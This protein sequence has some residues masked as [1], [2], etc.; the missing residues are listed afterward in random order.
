[1]RQLRLVLVSLLLT[2]GMISCKKDKEPTPNPLASLQGNWLTS[3]WGGA[4]GNNLVINISQTSASAVIQ[5][6]GS[7]T[8]NYSVG[9]TIL[10]NITAA[11]GSSTVFKCNAIFKYGTGNQTVA[12]TTAQI[13]L[14]SNNQQISILY[15]PVNGIQPP[16]YV[17]N[18]Q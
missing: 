15:A 2:A 3:D 16:V 18:K 1:M 14:Q 4:T 7:Q 9:E 17:Y 10:S 13:T 8:F 6:I 5:S 11:S 12:N